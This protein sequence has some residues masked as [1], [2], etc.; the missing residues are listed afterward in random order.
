V[1][2][3]ILGTKSFDID[4]DNNTS[5][6]LLGEPQ[7]IPIPF[8]LPPNQLWMLGNSDG[9]S[10]KDIVMVIDTVAYGS[11]T[12]SIA[13]SV[14][15]GGS[16]S[17]D[18]GDGSSGTR[19]TSWTGT[20]R[21]DSFETR[22]ES[23]ATGTGNAVH[24]YSKH[25][26][27]LIVIKGT[28]SS[29]AVTVAYPE[30]FPGLIRVLNIGQTQLRHNIIR[31]RDN[32]QLEYVPPFLPT[33][34][35]TLANCFQ[36]CVNF[37]HPNVTLWN[38]SN[39][40]S[41][42]AA[43]QSASGFNQDI[44]P[45]VSYSSGVTTF[46]NFLLNAKSFKNADKDLTNWVIR[47]GTSCQ[48]MFSNTSISSNSFSGWQFLGNNNLQQMFAGC[49]DFT[50]FGLNTWDV[51]KVSVMQNIFDGCSGYSGS[52]IENWNLAGLG[53]STS[54]NTFARGCTFPTGQYDLILNSWNANKSSGVN[55][56]ADWRTDLTPNFGSSKYT[57][58]GSG[59][60]ASLV[61]YGWTI[62]DGGLQT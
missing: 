11:T 21:P 9:I 16:F 52:G 32:R 8:H 49:I 4:I 44:S 26:I 31:F 48:A 51:S 13:I 24:T 37:N 47:S 60:R 34:I 10:N 29:A 45:W 58:A 3:G 7:P 42:V 22:I 40:T 55:G 5:K 62:T 35:T 33:G 56:V 43:F 36:N 20:R 27:Y 39:I 23:T 41:M 15:A 18:W 54:L 1:N 46:V 61:S 12:I 19:L 25:G 6:C 53:F 30:I 17:I 28:F 57:A 59:A 50:G 14:G 2:Q 38:L